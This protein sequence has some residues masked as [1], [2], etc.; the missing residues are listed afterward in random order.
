MHSTRIV[1]AIAIAIVTVVVIV[2]IARLS[3][4]PLCVGRRRI[5]Q[6]GEQPACDERDPTNESI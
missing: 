2:V 1:T 5:S 6:R 3:T 4:V